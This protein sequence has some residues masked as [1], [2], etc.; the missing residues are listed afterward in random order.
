M[1]RAEAERRARKLVFDGPSAGDL[2]MMTY[3][4]RAEFARQKVVAITDAL[5]AAVAAERE[6]CAVIAEQTEE[7]GD[8]CTAPD[9]G[10]WWQSNAD[11]TKT[12]IVA[13]IRADATPERSG[14]ASEP[15][16]VRP[17]GSGDGNRT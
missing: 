13:A 2:A 6:R 3:S 17:G 12:A 11:R 10:S 4:E 8:Y 16:D 14:G 1:N 9:G 15:N 5:L 7:E